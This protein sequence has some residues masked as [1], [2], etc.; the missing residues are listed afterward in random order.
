MCKASGRRQPIQ[1]NFAAP[2]S[3]P[4]TQRAVIMATLAEGATIVR[5]SLLSRETRFMVEACQSIG[6]TVGQLNGQVE[7][8]GIGP[9][10]SPYTASTPQ[11][12]IAMRYIWAG[13]S[14]LV[15]RTFLTLGSALPQNV[16]VDGTGNLRG[17]PFQPLINALRQKGVEFK[18]FG[19]N[20]HLPCAVISES[21][22]G[23][24]YRIGT[25]I[26]SQF[27]TA[28]IVSAPLA[29]SPLSIELLGANYS[30]S[31]IKQTIEMSAR[32]GVVI[33][34]D[35]EAGRILIP[36]G[37]CYRAADIG[38][39]GDF[40]SASYILGAAF[41]TRGHV[42]VS[43][44]DPASLQ[45]ERAIVAILQG[46]GAF[47]EWSSDGSVLNVDCSNIPSKVDAVFDL[48]DSPNILPTVAAI[49]ATVPGRVRIIGGRLTQNHKSPRIE[50]VA[51]EL[52][53]AGVSVEV[54][55]DRAGWIDGLEIRGSEDHEGG[56]AFSCHQDHRIVMSMMLFS[57]ACRQPC[58]FDTPPDTEDSFPGFMNL[59]SSNNPDCR[60]AG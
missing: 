16:I 34:V 17:R 38:V 18:F 46:L 3:K 56:V 19:D 12:S 37:Q 52:S 11:P 5:N 27:A 41:V 57:L 8:R 29:S 2:P 40:T 44:L 54:I 48:R 36:G 49:S 26:S 30:L 14:A 47:I 6:A 51:R 25:D 7:V 21:F 22:P 60:T 32:F 13:G 42:A 1:G 39:S 53:K 28:L 45:G 59:F 10:A 33:E 43:N 35:S 4:E 20:N 23:G 24:H 50:T 31:Y 15:A 58:S 55:K 9:V